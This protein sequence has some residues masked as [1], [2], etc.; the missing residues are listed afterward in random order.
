MFL[1]NHQADDNA[2][3]IP[4]KAVLI[5]NNNIGRFAN[6]LQVNEDKLIEYMFTLFVPTHPYGDILHINI[7]DLSML[8][9]KS[10]SSTDEICCR[11]VAEFFLKNNAFKIVSRYNHKLDAP[12]KQIEELLIRKILKSMIAAFLRCLQDDIRSDYLLSLGLNSE[13]DY[14]ELGARQVYSIQT[15]LQK[16]ASDKD[17]IPKLYTDK[18]ELLCDKF[19]RERNFL[20]VIKV[21][22]TTSDDVLV[23]YY[24]RNNKPT[25]VIPNVYVQNPV[26][27]KQLENAL[28]T[29]QY[30]T[31]QDIYKPTSIKEKDNPNLENYNDTSLDNTKEDKHDNNQHDNNLVQQLHNHTKTVKEKAK[32][33]ENFVSE[34][35]QQTKSTVDSIK[36]TKQELSE[37]ISDTYDSIVGTL[38]FDTN[39]SSTDD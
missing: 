28:E 1:S 23:S 31:P 3:D 18:L 29:L 5:T 27:R 20:N 13:K 6:T 16:Q 4:A 38:G 33:V 37:N 9:R 21:V 11:V 12:Y 8:V 26:I 36:Q 25:S 34:I 14:A 35:R 30:N 19:M 24:E 15:N 39:D 22:K 10:T 17:V 7:V 2:Y 32:N